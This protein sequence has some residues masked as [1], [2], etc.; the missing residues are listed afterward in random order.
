MRSLL[1]E[2]LARGV[3]LTDA[4]SETVLPKDVDFSGAVALQFSDMEL[5]AP[6]VAPNLRKPSTL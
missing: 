4:L 2:R 3:V 5:D 6:Y 1:V